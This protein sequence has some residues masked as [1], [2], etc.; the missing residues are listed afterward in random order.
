MPWPSLGICS[1]RQSVEWGSP[2]RHCVTSQPLPHRARPKC[3]FFSVSRSMP[4]PLG[5]REHGQ[6]GWD[7]PCGQ[8]STPACQVSSPLCVTTTNSPVSANHSAPEAWLPAISFPAKPSKK[9]HP[10]PRTQET[11]DLVGCRDSGEPW[12]PQSPPTVVPQLPL[13]ASGTEILARVSLCVRVV[14][15]L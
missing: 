10:H 5:R 2:A 12:Q 1:P 4:L 13:S 3:A 9:K 15:L 11:Q 7:V 6:E 8:G 14:C